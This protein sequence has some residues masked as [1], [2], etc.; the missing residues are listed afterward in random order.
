MI[1]GSDLQPKKKH[2]YN[3]KAAELDGYKFSSKKEARRF[4]ELQL[5]Q[6]ANKITD[7]ELQPRFMLHVNGQLVCD[8]VADF[9]YLEQGKTI[10]EDVKGYKGGSAWRIFRIKQ[11]LMKAVHGIDV[12]VI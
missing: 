12:Q 6:R 5:L 7:L 4:A 1:D 3:A 2:K 10:I 8:Y 11:K 9:Q